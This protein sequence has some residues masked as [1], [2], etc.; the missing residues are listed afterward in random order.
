MLSVVIPCFNESG[1]LARYESELLPELVALGQPYEAIL[2]DDGSIDTSAGLFS[3]LASRHPE[4][5]ILKHDHNQGL[6]AALRTGF[7]RAKGE[8]IATL[9]ADL[10]FHPRQ[11][12]D[13]LKR[14]KE[15]GADLVSGSPYM[16]LDGMKD[17]PWARRVPS[18]MINS[19]Y[20]GLFEPSFGSYTPIFR[21]YSAATLKNLPLESRGFEINAEIA[22]RFWLAQRR[23]AEAPAVL[24]TRREG[25]SK[26]SRFREFQRHARL[27]ARLVP[28]LQRHAH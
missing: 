27:I 16:T 15:T 10:T 1:S 20:R 17:V 12:K 6:G 13:L 19:V 26:L 3:M 8:W 11:L 24:E 25:V 4:I 28:E 23:L 21:L 5:K 18:F 14:Q 22:V 9:D 2:I 7:A